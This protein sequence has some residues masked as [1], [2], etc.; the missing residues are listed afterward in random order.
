LISNSSISEFDKKNIETEVHMCGLWYVVF[1]VFNKTMLS[2][3]S[4]SGIHK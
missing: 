2:A 3:S 1:E 4:I